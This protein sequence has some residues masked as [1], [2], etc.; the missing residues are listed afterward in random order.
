MTPARHLTQLAARYPRVWQEVDAGRALR[1]QRGIDW[2][3][4]CF[5]PLAIVFP[6]VSQ[7][8]DYVPPDRHNDLALISGLAA[9]RVGQGVYRF[10]PELLDALWSTPLRG[11]L[12]VE[13]LH[14]L[15]EW[16]VYVETPGRVAGTFGAIQGFFGWLDYDP[17]LDRPELRLLLDP[18]DGGGLVGLPVPLTGQGVEASVAEAFDAAV[19]NMRAAGVPAELLVGAELVAP[20]SAA[21]ITPLVSLL[22]YL[23]SEAAEVAGAWPPERPQAQRTKRGV[24]IFPPTAPK[25]WSV[26]ERIGAQLRAATAPQGEP[27]EGAP[28]GQRS[29][30]R[31]HLRRAHWHT[32]YTGA[33]GSGTPV[34]RWVAPVMVGGAGVIPTVHEVE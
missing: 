14:R 28:Q 4:W 6:L 13:V 11:D 24:R 17:I 31:A 7:G 27:G 8:A 10:A 29:A 26:G 30:P 15:P 34:L 2:P 1:G 9:W 12:P 21:A 20:R 33:R 23:C 18:A 5:L 16:G 19:A 32:Y 25:A 22:L 3:E